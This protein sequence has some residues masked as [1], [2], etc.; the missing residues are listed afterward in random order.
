MNGN[1]NHTLIDNPKNQS[2]TIFPTTPHEISDIINN[3]KC[4]NST[5]YD[6]INQ[7]IVIR[8]ASLISEILSEIVNSSFKMGI[9]PEELKIAK[10]IPIFKAGDK[11]QV[12]NYRP[13]SILPIFSKIFEKAMFDRLLKYFDKF[14]MLSP[15]QFGFRPNH[16][17]YMPLLSLTDSI[18]A[19][20]EAN[21][22]TIGIFLDLAKAFDVI[23]HKI[24]LH[25][26]NYYGIRGVSHRWFASFLSNRMQYTH[27]NSMNSVHLKIRYGV[28]QGSILGPL[29]F[30]IFINDLPNVSNFFKY[31]LF[32]DDTNV[33]ASHTNI[34]ELILLIN[35]ELVKIT[36][37]FQSNNLFLNVDK[38]NFIIFHPKRKLLPNNIP[39]I[40]INGIEIIQKNS[41][42]FLG[43]IIDEYLSWKEHTELIAR[44]V[45][46]NLNIIK[47]V[48]KFINKKALIQLYF[49][50][51]HPYLTY[52]NIVWSYNYKYIIG[53]IQI[54]QNKVIR[55]TTNFYQYNNTATLFKNLNIL[56][57]SDIHKYQTA[58]LMFKYS[59]NLLPQSF[60]VFD[61][62]STVN[63]RHSHNVRNCDLFSIPYAHTN[64]RLF[65][66]KF[67]GPRVWN[68]L[69]MTLR[70]I[71]NLNE[72]KNKLKQF[73]INTK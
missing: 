48:M 59:N 9:M 50:L 3:L 56:N 25:K 66:V 62:F 21:K 71:T 4:K 31:L 32:A 13:I 14:D 47:H 63:K 38:T 39:K 22:F 54:L 52:C 36:E 53:K 58:I 41:T 20:F 23:D 37:W 17:T 45:A 46:K 73:I 1:N 8:S 67:F 69:P 7:K 5:G 43:V 11:N 70:K 35:D 29:L 34:N 64:S 42:K 27:V 10:V 30:I 60:Y 44:K 72:F 24:L 6:E 65:T 2:F 68:S 26:L 40:K 55:L 57:L 49:T 16:A 51:I 19:N 15:S 18:S 28:P 61:Y 33:I 12:S